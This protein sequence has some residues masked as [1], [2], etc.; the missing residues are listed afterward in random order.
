MLFCALPVV[1]TLS[2]CSVFEKNKPYSAQSQPTEPAASESVTP[3]MPPKNVKKKKDK[4]KASQKG[5]DLNNRDR[6]PDGSKKSPKK[7]AQTPLANSIEG[8]WTISSVRG[9]EVEGEERPYINFDLAKDRFYGSNGCNVVNGDLSIGADSVKGSMRLDNV[10]STM[11]MCQDAP[12]EY[13]IN[14]ALADTRSYAIRQQ[15][16]LT[17]LDL[18]GANGKTIMVLRRHN[19]DFLNGAWAVETLNGKPLEVEDDNSPANITIDIPDLRIYGC[20]G[21]NIF[22]GD[23]FIDPDKLHSMQ[24][25]T[26][27]TTRKMCRPESRETE[28]LLALEE[29]E[30]AKAVSPDAVDLLD[31]GGKTVMTL[32]RLDL[33]LDGTDRSF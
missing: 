11:K 4:D 19:M 12:Y 26:I 17:F 3:L 1:G 18:K 14:L 22:N 20:T 15:A 29:V 30:S 24:F 21:C 7:Y 13:L 28:F 6:L 33:D 9:T 16:P 31:R 25:V 27:G 32:K 5:F 2:G 10:I 23:I 8:E